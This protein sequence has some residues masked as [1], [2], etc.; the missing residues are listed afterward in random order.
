MARSLARRTY[1]IVAWALVAGIAVQLA[2]AILG[3]FVVAGASGY[4]F[5][6]T[7]GR[8]LAL[9]PVLLIV[10]ALVGRVASR[11]LALVGAI[12]GLAAVQVAL[13][14]LSREGVSVAMA[15]HPVNGAA[16]LVAAGCLATRADGLE[17]EA[18]RPVDARR[19]ATALRPAPTA[20]TA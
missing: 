10:T 16:L 20:R 7:F 9:L 18:A 3:I 15:F 4:L 13:V 8:A 5:H 2:L 19:P 12:I 6:A 17:A 1:R 11:D 14:L